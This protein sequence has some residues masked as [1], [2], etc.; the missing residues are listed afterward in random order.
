MV[1][2]IILT[3]NQLNLTIQCFDSIKKSTDIDYEVIVVD[4]KSTDGTKE[5]LK[6]HLPSIFKKYRLILNE[7]NNGFAKGVNQGILSAKGDYICLLNNDTEVKDGWIT[8]LIQTLEQYPKAGIVGPVSSGTFEPQYV[9]TPEDITDNIFETNIMYGFCVVFR[10]E[11]LHKIGMLD[12]RYR[13]GNFEDHDFNERIIKNGGKII[14]D[15][16]TY[17]EHYCHSSWKSKFHLDYATVR[18]M[19]VFYEKWG[20]HKEIKQKIGSY[21]YYS[22]QESA[23]YV[24]TGNQQEDLRVL[25]KIQQNSWNSEEYIIVDTIFD[26]IIEDRINEMQREHRIVQVKVPDREKLEFEQLKQCGIRNSF[27]KKYI[28]I[29]EE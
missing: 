5:Y 4:N 17:I 26:Q 14:V 21:T 7:K 9:E 18:N 12:E 24:L 27:G 13:I 19:N 29:G 25:K 15:G 6:Q 20:F 28:V 11:L 22:C 23:I 10:R 8:Q 3:Y 2:I 1:S 16:R